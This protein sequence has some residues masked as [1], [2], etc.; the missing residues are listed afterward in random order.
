MHLKFDVRFDTIKPKGVLMRLKT[1][2]G[3]V[4]PPDEKKYSASVPI[5]DIPIPQ[6]VTIHLSQHIGSPSK[7]I[8]SVGDEVLTGQKIAESTG[9]VSLNQHSSIS[10]KVTAIGNFAN[11]T[12]SNSMAIQITGD[13]LDKWIEL[14][15]EPNFIDLPLEEMKKRIGEAGICGMGGAGFPTLVKLSPPD[16][17]PIDTVIL[18]GVECEPYLTSDHRLMLEKTVEI[19]LGMKLIM[20]ILGAQ[21]G[22]IGIEANKPDAIAKMQ[23]ITKNEPAIKVVPLQLRYPQ[24]AEKQLIY[25]ATKRK[26]PAGGLP[27]AVGVVVQNVATAFAIYEAIRY[28][29]PLVQ[30]VITVTGSPVVSP[31]NIMARIGTPLSELI[32]FC[33]GTSEEVGKVICGGPMMGFA[34]P[35]LEATIGKGSGGLVLLNKKAASLNEE[36]NCLRCARCVDVCPMNLVP[37]M[38]VSAIKYNNLDLAVKSGL[39][40]C[41]KCGACAYVCPAQIRLVQYIDTGKIRYAETKQ[42]KK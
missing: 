21:K 39:N 27:M 14:T 11:A 31:K 6:K 28:Q 5:V 8:V 1:F 23:E 12:G 30:R 41:I 42:A 34:L 15:D 26:V 4:H 7:P 2:P 17:K 19:V 32:E 37:C 13:G 29:K 38:I 9:F 10:G 24:G 16:D 20:K 33:G 18:N 36:G 25:A 22:M 40:D 35:S 3:G